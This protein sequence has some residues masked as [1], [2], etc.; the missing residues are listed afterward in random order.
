MAYDI[1]KEIEGNLVIDYYGMNKW[2]KVRTTILS[3][4]QIGE[5][6]VESKSNVWSGRITPFLFGS[7]ITLW[8]LLGA[9][10]QGWFYETYATGFWWIWVVTVWIICI[11]FSYFALHFM[12]FESTEHYSCISIEH[13]EKTTWWKRNV[14]GGKKTTVF[15][16]YQEKVDEYIAKILRLKKNSIVE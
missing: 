10:L 5:I 9:L 14:G 2:K 1:C 16:V 6:S 3:P 7:G 15:I 8:L 4:N 13:Q 11:F 12:I